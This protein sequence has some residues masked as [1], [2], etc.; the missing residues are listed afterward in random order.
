MKKQERITIYQHYLITNKAS[1]LERKFCNLSFF[2][3]KDE[4]LENEEY[5]KFLNNTLKHYFNFHLKYHFENI[6]NKK[7]GKDISQNTRKD[8]HSMWHIL[9]FLNQNLK[10]YVS[11]KLFI[12]PDF[13]YVEEKGD[14]Y[15]FRNPE[16]FL[17]NKNKLIE[18]LSKI[19]LSVELYFEE[20]KEKVEEEWE[21]DLI[22]FKLEKDLELLT[23]N[24]E[25]QDYLN[26]F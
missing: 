21:L 6:F 11:K 20:N 4:L 9:N 22:K 18:W 12:R 24:K 10:E 23:K 16:D 5:L 14:F 2:L 3:N 26:K 1:F 13:K 8:Y 15:S 7:D 19:D 17:K 25:K